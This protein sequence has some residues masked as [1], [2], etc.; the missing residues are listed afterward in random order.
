V[1]GNHIGVCYRCWSD[2]FAEKKIVKLQ[3]IYYLARA[4]QTA[5]L[6]G[7]ENNNLKNS[8]SELKEESTLD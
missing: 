5:F 6:L 1:G 7:P 4:T 3:S 8:I 2:L